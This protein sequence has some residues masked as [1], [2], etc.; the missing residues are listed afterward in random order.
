[1]HSATHP[2][3]GIKIKAHETFESDSRLTLD[4]IGN[5]VA[6]F[7]AKTA[8]KTLGGQL[9]LWRRQRCLDDQNAL[10][11]RKQHYDMLLALTLERQKQQKQHDEHK[12]H[13]NIDSDLNKNRQTILEHMATFQL[14]HFQQFIL[15]SNARISRFGYQPS[16]M[17]F[18]YLQMLKWPTELPNED[19]PLGISWLELYFNFQVVTGATIPVNVSATAGSEKLVWMD[20]QQVFTV[21]NFPYHRYVQS[22]RFCV[23]HLQKYSRG[24]WPEDSRRKTK[25]LHVLGCLGF[26]NGLVGRPQ[27]P[28]QRETV[29]ALNFWITQQGRIPSLI[30]KP[31]SSDQLSET[32]SKQLYK[33]VLAAKRKQ[34]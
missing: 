27:L 32:E 29:L 25:S 6:D 34:V 33:S 9:A 8:S 10:H 23:E 3:Q 1:M 28:Y 17:V 24:L 22:F 30:Q 12:E 14:T 26:R 19:V 16:M 5:A 13:V 15:P 18:E 2:I 21:D 11:I 20:E 31:D 4:R 7:V